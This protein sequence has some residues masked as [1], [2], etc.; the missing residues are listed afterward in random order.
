PVLAVLE[1]PVRVPG[2]FLQLFEDLSFQDLDGEDRYEPDHGADLERDPLA[3]WQVQHVVI[4]L[5]VVV[6]EADALAAHIGHRLGDVEEMLEELY[7]DV[8]VDPVFHGQSER[9]TQQVQRVHRHPRGA[10]R[11]I[12]MAAGRQRRAAVEDADIV[13][14]EKTALEDIAP[15]SVLL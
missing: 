12:D 7:R 4:E 15:A 10:V 9:D 5:V 3:A 6:P 8:L 14:A 13:E 1:E 2:E 11:L